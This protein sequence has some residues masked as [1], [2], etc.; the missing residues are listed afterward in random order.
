MRVS[1]SG[2]KFS[3][4]GFRVQVGFRVSGLG[5]RVPG[6]ELTVESVLALNWQLWILHTSADWKGFRD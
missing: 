6:F 3:G 5:C 4:S 1:G 2:F